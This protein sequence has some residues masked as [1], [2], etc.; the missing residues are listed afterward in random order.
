MSWQDCAPGHG[1]DGNGDDVDAHEGGGGADDVDDVVDDNDD[2]EDGDTVDDAGENLM[3]CTD[4]A[5]V[6]SCTLETHRGEV[7]RTGD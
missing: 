5:S 4:T 6:I 7:R 3:P 1:A 2:G